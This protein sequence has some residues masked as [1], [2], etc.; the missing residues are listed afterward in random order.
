MNEPIISSRRPQPWTSWQR[1]ED[2]YSEGQ[3]IWLDVDTLIRERTGGRR[4]LDTFAR[5]FYASAAPALTAKPYTFE[6]VVAGLN[7]VTP[8]DWAHFLRERLDTVGGKA[9]LDGIGRG[10]WRLVYGD[11]RSDFLKADEK[12]RKSATFTYSLG[13]TVGEGDKLT[14]VLWDSP[15]FNEGLT[16]GSEIHAVN[17]VNYD[18]DALRR[19]ITDAKAGAPLELL[20]KNGDRWRTVAFQYRDGLRYPRLERVRGAPDRLGDILR[21]RG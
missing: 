14:D 10:G 3:L 11:T 18:A 6:D 15:A 4:S 19:A 17:G 21:P 5:A 12:R 2:Y 20:V 16:V 9:P 1:P 8:Y 7:A 13:F